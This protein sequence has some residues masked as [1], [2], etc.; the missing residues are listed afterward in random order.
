ME[1]FRHSFKVEVTSSNATGVGWQLGG[2]NFDRQRIKGDRTERM[3]LFG[4][5]NVFNRLEQQPK[6]YNHALDV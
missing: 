6:L 2:D 5:R 4:G 1:L 3:A